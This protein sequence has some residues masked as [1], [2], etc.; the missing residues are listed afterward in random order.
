LKKQL[1]GLKK[2]WGKKSPIST[3]SVIP[4]CSNF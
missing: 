1:T 4:L 3:R 2:T